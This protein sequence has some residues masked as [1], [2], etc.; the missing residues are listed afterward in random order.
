M[1]IEVMEASIPR[2]QSESPEEEKVQA[3]WGADI[4]VI[5]AKLKNPNYE[6]CELMRLVTVEIAKVVWH[7]LSLEFTVEEVHIIRRLGEGIKAL[8]ELRH[9]IMDAESLRKKT[10]VINWHGEA[11]KHVISTEVSWFAKALK[12][13]GVDEGQRNTVWRNYRDL[14][15]MNEPQLHRETEAS[16]G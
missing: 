1:S 15:L 8:R 10:D 5:C 4:D 6:V 9:S 14:A 16:R 2:G 7:V 3:A 11:I 12:E 13:S